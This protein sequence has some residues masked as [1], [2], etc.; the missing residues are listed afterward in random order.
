MAQGFLQSFDHRLFVA[1]AG[2]IPGKAVNQKAIAVMLESGIDISRNA[3]KSVNIYLN[4]NWDYV[5]TVCDEANEICPYFPGKVNQRLHMSF[6]DPSHATGTEEFVMSEF[7]RVR[8]LIKKEFLEFYN[9]QLKP[10]L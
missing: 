9:N 3:P 10:L 5:I 6:E 1:S 4:E 2:T 7:R 8:D